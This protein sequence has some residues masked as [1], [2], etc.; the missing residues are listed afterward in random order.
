MFSRFF[1]K[2]TSQ[3]KTTSDSNGQDEVQQSAPKLSTDKLKAIITS[4]NDAHSIFLAAG[5]VMEQLDVEFGNTPKL[6]PRFKK[7]EDV[8][9][10]HQNMLLEELQEQQLIRFILIS[11]FKSNRM[12]SIF[13][14]SELYFYGMEID[15][16]SVPN[17]RT[18]FKRKDTMAEVIPITQ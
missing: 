15:I 11:L 13:D 1:G 4:L 5:Y 14:G 3:D 10:S 2:N 6:T 7:L 9:E 8:D 12:S 17:V 18:I 16:S